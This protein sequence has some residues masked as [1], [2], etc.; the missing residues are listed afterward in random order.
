MCVFVRVCVYVCV[1]GCV[2]TMYRVIL[3]VV[4][5]LAGSAP[6]VLQILRQLLCCCQ[7]SSQFRHLLLRLAFFVCNVHL[8]EM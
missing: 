2:F 1:C 7:L 8:L 4:I 6:F 5:L 3:I